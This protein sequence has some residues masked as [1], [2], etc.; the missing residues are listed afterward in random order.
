MDCWPGEKGRGWGVP[1]ARRTRTEERR[2]TR[3]TFRVCGHTPASSSAYSLHINPAAAGR[4]ALGLQAEHSRA[5]LR[6]LSA[7]TDHGTGGHCS[8]TNRSLGVG[9]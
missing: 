5:L 8:I 2:G 9:S 6:T 1:E 3:R 7:G 4:P